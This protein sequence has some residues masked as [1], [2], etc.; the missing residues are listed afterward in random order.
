MRFTI[1]NFDRKQVR[2]HNFCCDTF[3]KAM[4]AKAL[5]WFINRYGDGERYVFFYVLRALPRA[6]PGKRHHIKHCPWC[7]YKLNPLEAVESSD[8]QNVF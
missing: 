5:R 1:L 4:E 7:G 8:Y 2:V 6:E 3:K